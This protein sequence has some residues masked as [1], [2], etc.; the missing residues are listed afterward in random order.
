MHA[1]NPCKRTLQQKTIKQTPWKVRQACTKILKI[2]TQNAEA[3]RATWHNL[4]RKA[5]Q[6][7]LDTQMQRTIKE[8]ERTENL[9]TPTNVAHPKNENWLEQ[10]NVA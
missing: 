3:N 4:K 8:C 9:K 2:T 1:I 10:S 7:E 5:G 6:S